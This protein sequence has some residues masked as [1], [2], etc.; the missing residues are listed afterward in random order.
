M[1]E[2]FDAPQLSVNEDYTE[3]DQENPL[4]AVNYEKKLKTMIPSNELYLDEDDVD[5]LDDDE[6]E[7]DEEDEEDAEE[8]EEDEEM[9]TGVNI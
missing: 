6:F 5:D 8:E 9:D 3:F 2:Y 4:I 7:D 1:K